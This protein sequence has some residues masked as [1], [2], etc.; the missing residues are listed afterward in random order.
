M[1]LTKLDIGLLHLLEVFPLDGTFRVRLEN[2]IKVAVQGV[3]GSR[4]FLCGVVLPSLDGT[5]HALVVEVGVVLLLEA[6]QHALEFFNPCPCS[7]PL[8]A[9]TVHVLGELLDSLLR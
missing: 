3:I 2:L 1:V 6:L 5:L 9:H 7:V 8:I 4:P